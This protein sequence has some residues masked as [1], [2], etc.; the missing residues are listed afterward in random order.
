M[1]RV[2]KIYTSYNRN[3]LFNIARSKKTCEEI[4]YKILEDLKDGDAFKTKKDG[5]LLK[6]KSPNVVMVFSNDMP[7]HCKMLVDRWSVFNIVNDE[8]TPTVYSVNGVTSDSTT[9]HNAFSKGKKSTKA[10]KFAKGKKS[11]SYDSVESPY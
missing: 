7:E 5:Q 10:E 11:Y 2:N 9:V 8:L 4:N 1:S 6:I 3:F